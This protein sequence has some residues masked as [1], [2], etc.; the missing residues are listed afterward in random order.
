MVKISVML[1][2]ITVKLKQEALYNANLF[3]LSIMN[4]EAK[5][6]L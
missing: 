1:N 3:E 4:Y 5:P 6:A 2:S